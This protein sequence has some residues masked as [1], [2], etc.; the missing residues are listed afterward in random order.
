MNRKWHLTFLILSL[1][2][3]VLLLLAVGQERRG[4]WKSYQAQYISFLE[5]MASTPE[6]KESARATRPRI[7]QVVVVDRSRTDR[8][9]T[10][11][12]GVDDPRFADAPQPLTSH[13]K[14]PNH[15]F[16]RFGCTVCHSG[17]GQAVA[18]GDAHEGLLRE[19]GM[20]TPSGDIRYG[21]ER[22]RP[23][24]EGD[25]IY[26]SCV[27]CHFGEGRKDPKIIARGK[28]LYRGK[29]C[30]GC[31][32][33]GGV[34]G[35]VGPSLDFIGNK[36]TDPEWLLKH[37]TDPREASPGSVMPSYRELGEKRLRSLVAFVLSLRRVPYELVSGVPLVKKNLGTLVKPPK[38]RDHWDPPRGLEL[39][40]NPYTVDDELLD[41][42]KGVYMKYC[43]ACH[44]MEG[45]GD[46]TAGPNLKPKPADLS[47][48]HTGMDHP[49][50]GT[51]WKISTGRGLMPGWGQTFEHRSLWAVAEFVFAF[52]GGMDHGMED[53]AGEMQNTK[54]QSMESREEDSHEGSPAM[55][56][57]EE[58]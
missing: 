48:P 22:I 41:E 43:A 56:M 39:E 49:I 36:R 18:S 7:A 25:L 30:M 28:S 20:V 26:S 16:E 33:L 14:I 52:G 6:E 10:C 4:E 38:V 15:P 24:L 57:T 46:G 53:M 51:Y 31:H 32:R 55:N 9:T 17:I 54:D 11:H 2:S 45:K 58:H 35:K 29:G 23:V 12:A 50:E 8:C 5:E 1:L 37:F 44:G 21:E 13:P 34:G 42:G 40:K 27:S 47:K 19:E 3:V